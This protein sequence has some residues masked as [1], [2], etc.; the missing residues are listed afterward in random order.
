M[1]FSSRGVRE[2]DLGSRDIRYSIFAQ[3]T[4]YGDGMRHRRDPASVK[5]L[6]FRHVGQD[7][8]EMV[9]KVLFFARRQFETRQR[10]YAL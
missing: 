8:I 6:K 2:Q 7:R 3:G 5:G 10:G 4:W 1:V 9:N